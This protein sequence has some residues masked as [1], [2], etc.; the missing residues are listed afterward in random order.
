VVKTKRMPHEASRPLQVVVGVL[1][2]LTRSQAQLV[3]ENALLRQQ[4]IVASRKIQRPL[5][6]PHERR[7]TALLAGLVRG[8]LDPVLLVKP[9]TIL[10]W[11]REGFRL[12]SILQPREKSP[13]I[14]RARTVN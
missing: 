8:W 7:M 3:A 4:L 13:R 2:N 12:F 11:Y 10:R 9:E 6:K 5:F 14:A 1:R